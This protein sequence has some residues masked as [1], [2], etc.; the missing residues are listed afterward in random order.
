MVPLGLH[1]LCRL[2][3]DLGFAKGSVAIAWELLQGKEQNLKY[4]GQMAASLGRDEVK[5]QTG[6]PAGPLSG[7]PGWLYKPL[8]TG[9][10]YS[11]MR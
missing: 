5:H 10:P 8:S 6:R 1:L 9:V 7:L 11:F 4:L 2:G 3:S